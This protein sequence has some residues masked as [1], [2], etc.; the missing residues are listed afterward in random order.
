MLQFTNGFACA[1]D[2]DKT[3]VII[4][5]MQNHPNFDKDGNVAGTAS[6]SVVSIVMQHEMAAELAS[7]LLKMLSSD[8]NT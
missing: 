5:F 4:N 8:L 7:A 2:G 1:V 3:E 6:E